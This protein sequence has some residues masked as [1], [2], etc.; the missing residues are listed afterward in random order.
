MNWTLIELLAREQTNRPEATLVMVDRLMA[1]HDGID[2]LKY[3][4]ADVPLYVKGPKAGK[5]NYSRCTNR[6]E[7]TVLWADATAWA[8]AWSERTGL[9]KSCAGSGEEF[10]SWSA[11]HGTVMVDCRECSG[12]GSADGVTDRRPKPA[13]PEAVGL[14][15]ETVAP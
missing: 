8:D 3:G 12:T 11:D 15:A 1:E 6:Q 13:Q 2:A 9:C 5:P 7:R 14:F 10:K 4:V